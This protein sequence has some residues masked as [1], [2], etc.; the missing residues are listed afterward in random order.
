MKSFEV[1]YILLPKKKMIVELI[2]E[3]YSKKCERKRLKSKAEPL[4]F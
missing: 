1:L 3:K 2:I 4:L